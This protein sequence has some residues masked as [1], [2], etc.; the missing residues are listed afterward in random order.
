M[1]YCQCFNK[2]SASQTWRKR[3]KVSC[4]SAALRCRHSRWPLHINYVTACF[5]GRASRALHNQVGWAFL[6]SRGRQHRAVRSY[7]SNQV[8]VNWRPFAVALIR[9]TYN[10]RHNLY[11]LRP[12]LTSRKPSSSGIIAVSLHTSDYLTM[13]KAA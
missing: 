2:L 11:A 5:R 9:R 1:P 12:V 13:Y 10:R 7:I 4:M 3:Q 8:T 6:V